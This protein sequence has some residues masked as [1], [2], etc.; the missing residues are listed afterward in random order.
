MA[1][2]GKA[3]ALAVAR[4]CDPSEE[5]APLK[6]SVQEECV[7]GTNIGEACEASK[8]MP[9]NELIRGYDKRTEQS[10][11]VVVLIRKKPDC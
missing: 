8:V 6:G 2:H 9:S 1:R 3:I 10:Q 5:W 4:H 7:G 11:E